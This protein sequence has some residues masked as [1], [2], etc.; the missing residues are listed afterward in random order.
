MVRDITITCIGCTLMVTL[1]LAA[2]PDIMAASDIMD[3]DFR[4]GSRIITIG[5]RKYD[6]L[7]KCGKPSHTEA[8]EEVRLLRDFGDEAIT[9]TVDDW[10]YNLGSTYFIRYLRFENGR[11]TRIT[12]GDYGY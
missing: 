6:V 8:W 10:V 9:V 12:V 7:R 11:L 2:T 5:D 4:C 1:L 3:S